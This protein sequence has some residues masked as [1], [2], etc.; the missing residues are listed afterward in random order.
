MKD[1]IQLYLDIRNKIKKT[2]DDLQRDC[3]INQGD[4]PSSSLSKIFNSATLAYEIFPNYHTIWRRTRGITQAETERG[5]E[6]NA[7][8]VIEI[9][10]TIFV[11]SMSSFEHV[12]KIYHQQ[13]PNKLGKIKTRSGRIYLWNIMDKS[14][15]KK[16][17]Y[18]K[19]FKLWDGLIELRNSLVHNN[20]IAESNKTY[21]YPKCKLIFKKNKM[22]QG[23][24]KLFPNLM[25]WM[26]ASIETW[27]RKIEGK[28]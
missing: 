20:A 3:N 13:K 14:M 2:Q 11:S 24:L 18:K 19:D 28:K 22:V 9:Q 17:I 27:I 21:N 16:I 12:A 10:K 6:E 4:V 23:D 25:D 7:Q 15:K 26:I 5:K 8:R 1:I